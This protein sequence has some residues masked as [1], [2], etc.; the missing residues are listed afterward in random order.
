M[1]RKRI[2]IAGHPELLSRVRTKPFTFEVSSRG[3]LEVSLGDVHLHFD[4]IPVRLRVP[5]LSRR[6]LAGSIGP[7]GVRMKPVQA[8]VGIAEFVT[9]GVMGGDE[10]GFDFQL[11]G[12][13][14]A[15][16]EICDDLDDER[17]E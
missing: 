11:D 10:S 7:F 5:F 12:A 17:A 3:G 4:E 13:C 8:R 1:T 14:R 16:I 9:R 2:E 6:V 15:S